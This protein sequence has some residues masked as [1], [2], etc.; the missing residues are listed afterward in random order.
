MN[1][2]VK[3]SNKIL[4]LLKTEGVLSLKQISEKLNMGIDTISRQIK[5]LESKEN[6]YTKRIRV[7][8]SYVTYASLNSEISIPINKIEEKSEKPLFE[9]NEPKLLPILN[10]TDSIIENLKK[11]IEELQSE[12][13]TIRKII[14]IYDLLFNRTPKGTTL[15]QITLEL[16]EKLQIELTKFNNNNNHNKNSKNG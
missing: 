13:I 6:L 1:K 4:R 12:R 2:K 8:R 10:K 11:Q 5:T 7:G 15:R 9:E 3:T 14:G 16:I